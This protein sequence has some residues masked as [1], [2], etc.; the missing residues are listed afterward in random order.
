MSNIA[1]IPSFKALVQA[2]KKAKK[3]E[4]EALPEMRKLL[5]E[6][7]NSADKA[8]TLPYGARVVWDHLS[9][10]GD[11]LESWIKAVEDNHE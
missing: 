8:L 9:D 1:N 5:L 3:R 7:R 10:A 2:T 11:H 4:R 6:I